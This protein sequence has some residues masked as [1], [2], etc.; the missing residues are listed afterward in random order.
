M[1]YQRFTPSGGKNIGIRKSEFVTK[2]QFL[3]ADLQFFFVGFLNFTKIKDFWRQLFVILSINKRSMGFCKVPHKIWA[4]LAE[5]F[6]LVNKQTD[7]QTPKQSINIDIDNPNNNELLIA[8]C[9]VF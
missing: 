6:P 1:K 2:A 8:P 9:E 7:T 5:P 4:C 3:F